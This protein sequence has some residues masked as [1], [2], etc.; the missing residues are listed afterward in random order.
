[1]KLLPKKR[2][3]IVGSI[4]ALCSFYMA[5]WFV[6]AAPPYSVTGQRGVSLSSGHVGQLS[7]VY[8]RSPEN[9]RPALRNWL[10]LLIICPDVQAADSQ[11][12]ASGINRDVMSFPLFHYDW[13]TQSG[14]VHVS[15]R[16]N[17]WL[18]Y[19]SIGEQKFKRKDGNVFV[20]VRNPD[21]KLTARQCGSLGPLADT[22][23]VVRHIRAQVPKDVLVAAVR[24]HGE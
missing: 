14:T 3:F 10:Y 16:W 20:V 5:L 6:V 15:F 24:V 8:G 17:M 19:I 18:D 2:L 9:E 13:G 12:H 23:E 11:S 22:P 1:M 7:V 4:L 21:G